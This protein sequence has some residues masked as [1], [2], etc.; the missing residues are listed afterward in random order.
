MFLPRIAVSWQFDRKT[1][2]RGGFGIYYDT[3]NSTFITPNQLGYSATTVNTPS[4]DFGMTWNMGN[5][6]MGISPLTD[7]FPV[8]GDGTRFDGA[9][10]DS[11][12]AM[13]V[14]GTSFT[15]PNLD[16]EHARVQRWRIGIQRELGSNMAVEAV[17]SGLY[18]GNA[19]LTVKQDVLAENY[20]NGT[21]VRNNALAS[22]LNRNITNPFHISNFAS[23][24]QSD[25]LL[26]NRLA[27]LSFFASPTVQK[28][29]LLRPYPHMSNL[30][31][32][33]LPIRKVRVHSLDLTFQRR[34]SRG[35]NL[36]VAFSSN[37][38]EE[39]G[40]ILNEYELAPTQWLPTDTARPYR[41]TASGVY[42][43]PFGK[44][45]TWWR[46][47][48]LNAI[49]GGWQTSATFEW[50]P[51]PLLT[52]GNLFFYGDLEDIKEGEK[53]LDR[54][55]NIDA[56]F[57]R[58]AAKV[59]AGFQKRVFPTVIDGLRQDKLQMLNASV[60]KYVPITERMQLQLR[61]DAN[62]ALN[63]SHFAAPNR[64]TTSTQFGVVS[65]NSV[66]INRW[67]TVVARLQF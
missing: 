42:Q 18:G 57:E 65:N 61:L 5:P 7:P 2:L 9:V 21:Q 20:W 45:R 8:R 11:L 47:G 52:W 59:P 51:G 26:Y 55:F 3:L 58:D 40:T 36:N 12:G 33:A 41:F 50:Q 17:Y 30:N 66:T 34:F 67:I 27:S 39:W 28:Q 49:A 10:R 22:D 19:D 29:R 1:V 14:A 37:R 62:N 48:V 25:P 31:A 32:A 38:G 53:T 60:Q 64:T 15:Y 24:K 13:M 6:A 46:Q 35:F 4:N 16:R 43:L 63:R 56:G 23:L 44:G 54:W